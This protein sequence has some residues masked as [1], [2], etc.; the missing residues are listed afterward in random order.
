[1]LADIVWFGFMIGSGLRVLS[2]IPRI[3]RVAADKTGA[4]AIS[5]TMWGLWV[6]AYVTT[7][8]YAAAGL[9]NTWLAFASAIYAACCATVMVLTALKRAG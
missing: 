5:Y 9:H 8:V 4:A 2:Y 3:W 6:A 1:M 7:A